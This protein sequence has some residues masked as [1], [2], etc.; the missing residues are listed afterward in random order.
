MRKPGGLMVVVEIAEAHIMLDLV[1][2]FSLVHRLVRLHL[3][4]F[5]F[6]IAQ[7]NGFFRQ[8]LKIHFF[9]NEAK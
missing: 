7:M 4:S 8:T 2:I 6:L 9:L 5:F 1:S 3:V